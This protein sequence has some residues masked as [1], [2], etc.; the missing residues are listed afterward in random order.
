MTQKKLP[1]LLARLAILGLLVTLVPAMLAQSNPVPFIDEPLA[2]TAAAPGSYEL[3]LTVN[4]TGFAQ[5]SVVSWNGSPLATTYVS[6]TRLTAAVPPLDIASPG[7]ASVT[8]ASPGSSAGS[9]AVFLA[10][11]N[12][13]TST[14]LM[15]PNWA[16]PYKATAIAVA[17]FNGDGKLDSASID[18]FTG[19]LSVALGNGDGTFQAPATYT[20]NEAGTTLA[21]AVGD[22]NGDGKL[23]VAVLDDS[24]GCTSGSVGNVALLLGNGDGTF[25]APIFSSASY[26]PVSIVAADFN[27]DGKLDVAVAGYAGCQAGNPI[28]GVVDVLLGNG[29]GTFQ[30]PLSGPQSPWGFGLLAVGDFNGDGLLDLAALGGSSTPAVSIFLGKGDGTLQSSYSTFPAPYF[31]FALATA[32]LNGDGKLDLIDVNACGDVGSTCGIYGNVPGAAAILLGNGDGTF[33]QYVSYAV[34]VQPTSVALGDFNGD[35]KL[36]LAVGTLCG[37]DPQCQDSGVDALSILLGNGDGTFQPQITPFLGTSGG[38]EAIAAGDFNDDGLLD[39]I[40]ARLVSVNL[41]STLSLNTTNLTFGNQTVGTGSQ[42][43][44]LTLSNVSTKVPITISSTQVTGT[45]ASDFSVRT[46]CSKLWAKS[47]CKVNVTFKPTAPGTRTATVV[48]TDSAVGSPHQITVTGTGR[49]RK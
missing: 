45:N 15:M 20:M 25:Q 39:P 14:S 48:V 41:Q 6:G 21:L 37:S 44:A 8:V 17:D 34:G 31:P 47:A 19:L 28:N 42:P 4:G 10:V 18:S 30:S 9:Y 33:Q 13:T 27:G 26:N 29:D 7:T 36:D 5:G 40:S 3:M 11:T 2:P 43:Q 23:D 38:I 35:G 46:T 16:A 1:S 12:P 49:H 24:G 32:D 22:F